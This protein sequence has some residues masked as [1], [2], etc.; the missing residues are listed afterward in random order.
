MPLL[1]DLMG[2]IYHRLLAEAKY[3]GTYYTGIPAAALLLKIALRGATADWDDMEKL[4]SYRAADLAA[5]TGTL[6]M[7][8]ADTIC[9]LH[10][11]VCNRRDRPPDISGLHRILIEIVLHGFDGLA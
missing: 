3:L 5:G 4:A 6:L 2:R 1:H 7:A 10:I 11:R 8:A 9:D